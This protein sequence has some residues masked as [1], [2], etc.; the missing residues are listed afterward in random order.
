[1]KKI[2]HK[3]RRLMA[4]GIAFASL[5]F[6]LFIFFVT[7]SV[8]EV[9][10][11]ISNLPVIFYYAYLGVI[12]AVIVAS[13]WVIIKILHPSIEKKKQE[14]I[15]RET[16]LKELDEAKES[17]MDT[18][19]LQYEI[20]ELQ[21]RKES[22]AIYVAI[23]GDV[24]T[25]KSSIIKTLLPDAEVLTDVRA[26][27]TSEIN[28]YTWTSRSGDQLILT[29]LP[30]RSEAEGDLDE[31]A[32]DEAVRAQVVIYVTDSDLTR[33]QFNDILT[34]R[35]Y[36]KPMIVALNKSDRFTDEEQGLLKERFYEQ[37]DEEEP[38]QLLED[39]T[40]Q[41]QSNNLQLTFIKSGGTEEVIRIYPDGREEKVLRPR[42]ADVSA[43]SNALQEEIDAQSDLLENLRDASV[44]VLVKQKLDH[45][46]IEFRR[47]KAS[48]I[49]TS[50]TRKAVFGA[51]ASISPGTD[52]L[53]QGVLA[54]LM[55]KKLCELYEVPMRKLDIEKF[56]NFS[57]GQVK[58]SVP[59]LLAVAGNGMKA[60]PGIG[61][62]TGGLT[63]AVAY[64]MIFD[65]LGKATA[66][67]LEE[68][69][70]LRAA[71]AAITF[72]EMLSENM[73]ARARLFAKL[74]FD[75]RKK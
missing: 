55:V 72:K 3:F 66:K 39:A 46:I 29:D 41:S 9:W 22:G 30:G 26:G 59:I 48:K 20:E 69:G 35:S 6:L 71:P 63:H 15:D 68:R 40:G 36:G 34:L 50:S 73:E 43:L 4:V 61:T 7:R 62:V 16:V 56:L 47:E 49:I 45:E 42:K 21:K 70:Q 18:T 67:T 25:G 65:A 60:F 11:Y 37:F 33:S 19:E 17:G 38:Q 54:T 28:E 1:M 57:Q 64:G 53:I 8:L 14:K 75:N 31:M 24:S 2:A 27:S 58:K 74:V 13:A 32:H 10:E 5:L 23:F 12:M 44:F 52:L 51:L